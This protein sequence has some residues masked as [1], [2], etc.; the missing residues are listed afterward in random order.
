MKLKP[1]DDL[2]QAMFQKYIDD[3]A[4]TTKILIGTADL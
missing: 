1:L 4:E 3:I 2:P